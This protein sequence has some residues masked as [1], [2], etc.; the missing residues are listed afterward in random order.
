MV[1][2]LSAAGVAPSTRKVYGAGGRR[3]RT[4]CDQAGLQAHPVSEQG[5]FAA[6]LF[7][8][9]L[10]HGTIKSYL[11]AI[12]YEQIHLGLGD[13]KIY[14]M[15]QLEYLFKGIKRSTPLS[16][17]AR[18]PITPQML[19]D[20]KKVWQRA[21]IGHH[22]KLMWAAACLCFFGFLRSGEVVML[23]EREYDPDVH[24]CYQD[25]KVDSHQSPTYLQ[26]TLKAS[27]TDPF[28]QGV[29]VYVGATQSNIFPV[30]AVLS[31]M[32][33]RGDT[34]GPLF[35]EEDGKYL[36][37][38]NFVAG[39]RSAL[40]EAGYPAEKYAGHSFRIGAATAAG[41]CGIQDSLIKTLGRWE[42][43]AYTS[44]IRTPPETLYEVSRKL[45]G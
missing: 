12:R 10:S 43:S 17:R 34:S 31:F 28:R 7:T 39:V 21:P 36:T 9:K 3:Y 33:T 22:E 4:F 13:P 18:L 16:T 15:P 5:W 37:R 30:A 6:H 42:S 45:V 38:A 26:V 25:I 20:M 8:E 35:R 40:R 32:V 1:Q 14:Q 24:L 41:K 11:A 2:E 44:Y 19:R 29:T 27:K 23:S